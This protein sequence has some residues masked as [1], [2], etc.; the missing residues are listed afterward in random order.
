MKATLSLS[1]GR[2]PEVR[3][4]TTQEGREVVQMTNDPRYSPPPQ[5]PGHRA[6]PNAA[7]CPGVCRSVPA[8]RTA[9]VRLAVCH[10]AAAA[11]AQPPYDPYRVAP[12]AAGRVPAPMPQKRS[13]A[14]ALTAG[15]VA[16]AV[17]SAGIGGGVALL[18]RPDAPAYPTG[19]SAGPAPSVPAANMPAR[20]RRAGRGQGGA[21]RGQAGDRSWP[22][23][24]RG[25]GHHPVLR[26]ADPDQQPRRRGGQGRRPPDRARAQTKVTFADGS[27][28]SFTVVGT[29][30]SQR[31]RRGARPQGVSG[32]TPI[33]LGSSAQSAGRPGRRGHR[34]A[35]RPGGHRHHRHRQRAEPAGVHRRATPGTRTPCSTR[36]RPTPR[37]TPATPAA[38]WST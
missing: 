34:L 4:Q 29:D 23:D 31:H 24:R 37:S 6:D 10:P 7:G 5:H 1:C 33:T 36:S 3:P 30:P 22:S 2:A 26:R 38:R 16:I 13:R 14:G 9:A 35:A 28:T 8:R 21:Q 18:A 19:V 25:L 12:A 11:A 20:F 15:A 17:V 27:T 32:L